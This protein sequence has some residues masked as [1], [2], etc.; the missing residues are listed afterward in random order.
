ML[1]LGTALPDGN[2]DALVAAAKR[3]GLLRAPALT[4]L[5]D[6][7]RHWRVAIGSEPLTREA[8]ARARDATRQMLSMIP[9]PGEAGK[10]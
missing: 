1:S 4:L 9:L 2:P 3:A 10:R 5:D 6:L 8:A 7:T